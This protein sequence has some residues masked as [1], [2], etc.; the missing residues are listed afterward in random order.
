MDWFLFGSVLRHERV[1][2]KLLYHIFNSLFNLFINCLKIT[3]IHSFVY[4]FCIY[5][6]VTEEPIPQNL[7]SHLPSKKLNL[8]Q[9]IKAPKKTRKGA[10]LTRIYEKMK[11]KKLLENQSYKITCNLLEFIVTNLANIKLI[12]RIQYLFCNKCCFFE[13][14]WFTTHLTHMCKNVVS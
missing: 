13:N 14:W 1:R 3:L 12:T 11:Q 6:K 4:Y 10:C 2:D 8:E 7:Y 5:E 9:L